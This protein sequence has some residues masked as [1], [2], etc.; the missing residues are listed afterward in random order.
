MEDIKKYIERLKDDRVAESK[1]IEYKLKI[2]LETD[3]G[4][5]EFLKD[6][7]AF[8][9][10]SGGELIIG[11]SEQSQGVINDIDGVEIDDIDQFKQRCEQ[12]IQSCLAPRITYNISDELIGNN[13]YILIISINKSFVG[14]H[15]V[16]Y[17]KQSGPFCKRHSSGVYELDVDE[18][19][20]AFNYSRTAIEQL[21][22]FKTDRIVKIRDNDVQL[23]LYDGVKGVLHI[24]PLSSIDPNNEIRNNWQQREYEKLLQPVDIGGNEGCMSRINF[25]GLICYSSIEESLPKHLN[26][27]QLY[28]NGCIEMV[29]TIK[30]QQEKA[31][32]EIVAEHLISWQKELANKLQ[33]YLDL[34]DQ[35][36][37][38]TPFLINLSVTG[39]KGYSLPMLR[40]SNS[41]TKD[42]LPM[43]SLME[44]K[45]DDTKEVILKP[46]F[47]RLWNAW[48]ESC[49]P[50]W[51]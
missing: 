41:V 15:R 37:V 46:M 1:K 36:N 23:P 25:E 3:N 6:V 5:K 20:Q 49:S 10:T 11:V 28:R 24:L 9:N 14:P 40:K 7:S 31:V 18:L 39:V 2:D 13:K 43:E 26:Y 29:S 22:E 45:D 51:L 33:N 48:G 32:K 30:L 27:T 8:A 50:D 12:I 17:K 34:L 35:L 21:R 16:I 44:N 47:D 19:R 4:K 42:I 38:Y